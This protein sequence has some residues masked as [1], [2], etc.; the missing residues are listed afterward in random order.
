MCFTASK[1]THQ[2]LIKNIY[3]PNNFRLNVPLMNIP[4]FSEA[5]KCPIGSPMNPMKKCQ[6]F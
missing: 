6:L 3:A 1:R 2:K 5:F 4:E